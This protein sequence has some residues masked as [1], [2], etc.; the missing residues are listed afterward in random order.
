MERALMKAVNNTE[1][2]ASNKVIF[3]AI[4][5]SSPLRLSCSDFLPFLLQMLETNKHLEQIKAAFG[6]ISGHLTSCV[7]CYLIGQV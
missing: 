5:E 1:L 3:I 6:V 4:A 2:F 7:H